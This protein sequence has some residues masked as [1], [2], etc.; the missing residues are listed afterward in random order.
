MSLWTFFRNDVTYKMQT[1]LW[2]S[3]TYFAIK[4]GKNYFSIKAMDVFLGGNQKLSIKTWIH[5]SWHESVRF[6]NYF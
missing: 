4:L 6:L 2:W 3:Y 1:A 5:I